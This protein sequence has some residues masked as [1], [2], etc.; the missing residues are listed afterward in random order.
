MSPEFKSFLVGLLNKNPNERMNWPK[1]LEHPFIKETE[2]EKVERV[3]LEE[4]FNIW[5]NSGIFQISSMIDQEMEKLAD[6][7]PKLE[8][9]EQQDYLNGSIWSNYELQTQEETGSTQLRRD[10]QFLEKLIRLYNVEKEQLDRK[11]VRLYQNTSVRVLCGM[12]T[13]SKSDQIIDDDIAKDSNLHNSIVILMNNLV[14]LETPAPELLSD[15][16]RVCGF[17]LKGIFNKNQGILYEN[18]IVS[19]LLNEMNKLMSYPDST[20]PHILL[21]I[22]TIKTISIFINQAGFSPIK[23]KEMFNQVL[24]RQ[25]Y[26]DIVVLISSV[27]QNSPGSLHRACIH[28]LAVM[29]HINQGE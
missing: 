21:Q 18:K 7:T 8:N 29:L 11:D 19:F 1:L 23:S 14:D 17:L 15:I 12:M 24:Y 26:K 5:L 16:V 20:S 27:K 13:K 6:Y 10:K 2:E 25:I 28:A 4:N 9:Q 3:Q 22:N